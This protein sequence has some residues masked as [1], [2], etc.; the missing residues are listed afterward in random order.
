MLFSSGLGLVNQAWQFGHS[1]MLNRS[2]LT[3]W[4]IASI[5]L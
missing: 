2:W 4:S 3:V 5:A 1:A